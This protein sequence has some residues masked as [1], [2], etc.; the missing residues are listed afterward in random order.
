VR[1]TGEIGVVHILSESSSA[2]NVRR[3]EALTG[4]AAVELLRAR[5]NALD[6]AAAELRVAPEAVP[7]AVR[8]AQAERRQLQRAA[9]D[10]GGGGGGSVDVSGLAAAAEQLPGTDGARVL[11][12]A[13]EVADAKALLDVA[14]SLKQ[15]LGDAVIVLGAGAEGRA[16]LVVSVSPALVARGVKAGAIIKAAAA[17][18][19]GGGGG[20]DTLAQ[21]GGR[22]PE[23]LPEA[24]QTARDAI[25]TALA[26]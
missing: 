7:D 25:E 11:V 15:S 1:S 4:P 3:I 5:A 12:S 8:K 9:R 6:E 17:V 22:D 23:R 13:V 26:P 10:G 24:L 16:Q 21:A 19:G 18:V 2:A 20:R 14:D